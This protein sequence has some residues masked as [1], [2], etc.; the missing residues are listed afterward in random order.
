MH[1]AQSYKR[2]LKLQ[3]CQVFVCD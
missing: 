2:N 1:S 3:M